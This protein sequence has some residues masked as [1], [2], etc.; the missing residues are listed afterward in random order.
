MLLDVTPYMK[1]NRIFVPLRFI[2]ETFGSNVNY[3]NSIVTVDTK[4]LVIDGVIVKALQEEYH[5]TLGGVIQQINGNAY[6]EAIYNIFIEKK[7]LEFPH[8]T[9]SL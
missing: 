4:P 8:V 7:R 1:K 3:S 9:C 2:A 6:N 5:M